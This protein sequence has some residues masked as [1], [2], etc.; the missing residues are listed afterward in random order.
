MTKKKA[1]PKENLNEELDIEK[2]DVKIL[3]PEDKLSK[4]IGEI[5]DL[6]E[7]KCINVY[8]NR[9][10]INVFTRRYL[11]GSFVPRT[12]IK[13]SFFV[14]YEKGKIVDMTIRN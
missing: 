6:L 14:R 12:Q 1:P 9:F 8:D 11:E 10:R 2:D 3:I 4:F 5:K 7:I 13:Q